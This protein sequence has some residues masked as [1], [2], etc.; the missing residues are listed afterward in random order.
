MNS[1]EVNRQS[2]KLPLTKDLLWHFG[3]QPLVATVARTDPVT[4]EKINKLRKSYENHLKIFGLA[5]RNKGVKGEHPNRLLQLAQWPDEEYY[6]QHVLGKDLMQG[7]PAATLQK[8]DKAMQMQPGAVPDNHKW[9]DLLGHEKSKPQGVVIDKTT[10]AS[11]TIAQPNGGT[12]I[13]R[14]NAVRAAETEDSRPV[15]A[16]KRRRYNDNSFEGYAEGFEDDDADVPIGDGYSSEEH[17]RK[18]G[19]FKRRKKVADPSSSETQFA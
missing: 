15:R 10:K 2:P 7:L 16:G 19:S 4:G 18:G 14:G 17:S 3:L 13:F 6:N 12:T 8:L 5:G 1:F 11:G 9:E